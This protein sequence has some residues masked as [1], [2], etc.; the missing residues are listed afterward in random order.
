MPDMRCMKFSAMRSATRMLCA[1]PLTSPKY[2]S[3]HNLVTISLPP[4]HRQFCIYQLK[5]LHQ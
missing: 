2:C 5:H 3:F 4:L 1:L